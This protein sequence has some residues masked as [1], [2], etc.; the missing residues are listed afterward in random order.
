MESIF[1]DAPCHQ[2]Q[3]DCVNTNFD[4][5]ELKFGI[6]REYSNLSL[7]GCLKRELRRQSYRVK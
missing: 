6:T 5:R 2:R 1:R 3:F 7:T 4:S